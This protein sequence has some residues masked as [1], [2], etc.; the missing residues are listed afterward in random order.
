MLTPLAAEHIEQLAASPELAR[1]V[2]EIS[3]QQLQD[4]ARQVYGALGGGSAPALAKAVGDLVHDAVTLPE[5]IQQGFEQR[6]ESLSELDWGFGAEV[7]EVISAAV[8][9]A[10]GLGEHG[11]VA[12]GGRVD[13]TDV[14]E[15]LEDLGRELDGREHAAQILACPFLGPGISAASGP[16]RHLHLVISRDLQGIGSWE[17]AG[18]GAVGVGVR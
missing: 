15:V 13:A 9:A 17:T 12:G 4:R 8:A 16:S 18:R 3:S 2:G 14:F 11:L 1:A 5:W 10:A 7:A 6:A